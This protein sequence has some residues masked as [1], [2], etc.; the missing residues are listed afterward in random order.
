MKF[1]IPEWDDQ[2]DAGYNFIKDEYSNTNS[3][4]PRQKAYMWALFPQHQIPFDGILVSLLNIIGRKKKYQ[5]ILEKGGIRNFLQLPEKYPILADCGAWGY[6][7]NE[8]EGPPFDSET[9]F[10]HYKAMG[11]NEGVTVDHLVLP[12]IKK[13]TKTIKVD[14]QRRM[15]ITYQNGIQGHKLWK[16]QHKQDFDLLVGVQGLET[17][18]YMNM[19]EMYIKHDIDSF[20]F[21]GLAKKTTKQVADIIDNIINHIE[22]NDL[23]IRK[24]HFFGLGREQLFKRFQKVEKYGIITSFDT[25]SWLRQAWLGGNYHLID[26]GQKKNYTAIRVPFT[27]GKRSSF[28]GKRALVDETNLPNLIEAEKNVMNALRDDENPDYIDHALEQIKSYDQLVQHELSRSYK[29]HYQDNELKIKAMHDFYSKIEPKYSG[30]LKEQPW[31]KCDCVLCQ[32]HGID[33]LIF[34]GNDRNRRRGFHNVYQIYFN[35]LNKP[36]NWP[37]DRKANKIKF[38]ESSQDLKK[39]NGKVLVLTGC[40]KSKI[41][42]NAHTRTSADRL[43]TGRLF[44]AVKLFAKLK[45]FDFKIISAK[46]GLIDSDEIIGGYEKVLKTRE[47]IHR[48][49]PQVTEKLAQILDKYDTVLVIAGKNYRQTLED[50]WDDRFVYLKAGGYALMAKKVHKVID[51]ESIPSLKIYLE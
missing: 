9:V 38:I 46:Y 37:G 28:K 12:Q 14:T 40:T 31:K 51:D 35:L 13:G 7:N 23:K 8:E 44:K 22:E 27:H 16:K 15:D 10:K 48:I 5:T 47:D 1:Y 18:D 36:E 6:I 4:E 30:V 26:K 21:G 42:Y 45:K 39:I 20:A 49:K 17:T 19:F 29:Q 34:R 33:I 2:V 3:D 25:S 43:Y 11:V 41:G 50:I 32:E 24:I